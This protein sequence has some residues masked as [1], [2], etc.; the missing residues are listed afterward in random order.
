MPTSLCRPQTCHFE[1]S[2]ETA[3]P[4]P[5]PPPKQTYSPFPFAF[6]RYGK[7]CGSASWC[8]E[9]CTG[10]FCRVGWDGF[11]QGYGWQ[12]MKTRDF[13]TRSFSSLS[14]ETFVNFFFHFGWRFGIEKWRGFFGEYFLWYPFPRKQSTQNPGKI[15]GKI[16]SKIRVG[17]SKKNSG[18]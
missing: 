1:H 13:Q 2:P 14:R 18:R 16:R 8:G 17:N 4:T 15:R 5:P 3:K 9:M 6:P 10:K 12:F 7:V 11:G